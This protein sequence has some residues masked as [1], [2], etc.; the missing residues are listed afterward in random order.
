MLRRMVAAG[1]IGLLFGVWV[2][3][4]Q[5]LN[6]ARY[7]ADA[8][9]IPISDP[10]EAGNDPFQE[11]ERERRSVNARGVGHFDRVRLEYELAGRYPWLPRRARSVGAGTSR[12]A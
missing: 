1:G 8:S 7:Y 3:R 10:P 6:R 9:S 2:R 11:W 4:T 5:F 12:N